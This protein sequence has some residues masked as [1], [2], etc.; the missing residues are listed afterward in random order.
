MWKLKRNDSRWKV[1]VSFWAIDFLLFFIPSAYSFSPFGS[2]GAFV[3]GSL[4]W[5]SPKYAIYGVF[6]LFLVFLIQ[7]F[8][9]FS[10]LAAY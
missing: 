1:F 4:W 5:F 6:V 3:L 7:F 8:R 10:G 9:F 2:F